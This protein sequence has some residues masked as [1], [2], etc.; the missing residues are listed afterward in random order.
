MKPVLVIGESCSDVYQYFQ[1]TRLSPEAPIP[2]LQYIKTI[3]NDGM[4]ANVFRNILALG[5]PCKHHTTPAYKENKKVRIVE[6]K[7]NHHYCRTDFDQD[8]GKA[9]LNTLHFDTYSA[10]VI[11]DYNKSFLSIEDIQFIAK[12]CKENN[13]PSWLDTKKQLGDWANEITFIKVNH[14]EWDKRDK[15]T[16]KCLENKTIITQGSNGAEFQDINY[17]VPNVPIRDVSGC[18]DSFLAGLVVKYL[19]AGKIEEAI[20]FANLCGTFVAQQRGVAIID[21]SKIDDEILL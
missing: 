12:K 18:G 5:Y 15:E 6:E 20:K 17:P 8:Y 7:N 16:S 10:V 13:I 19:E 21:R 9:Q 1:A 2:V 11:S 4:S 14:L 3:E